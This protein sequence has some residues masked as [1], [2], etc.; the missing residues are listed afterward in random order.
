MS[1]EHFSVDGTL[2]EAW[3]SMKSFRPKDGSG[4]PPGPGRNGERD[5]GEAMIA[6]LDRAARSTLGGDK[7]YD[8][9]GFVA[10]CRRMCV[11]PHVAAKAKHS[12]IDRRT[13]RHAAYAAS[14]QKRKLIEECFDW[15]KTIGRMRKTQHKGTERVGWTFVL[16]GAVYNLGR[17]RNLIEV[18]S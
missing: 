2:I 1:S 11:T 7:N 4:A 18:P 13:M 17:I 3:A 5:A 14:Q 16:A 10:E 8:T 9:R 15:M 6:G 12:A